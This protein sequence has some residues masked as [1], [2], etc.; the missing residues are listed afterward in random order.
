MNLKN[1]VEQKRCTRA[2]LI[3]AEKV[4]RKKIKFEGD[5]AFIGDVKKIA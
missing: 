1:V 4:S 2:I 5:V 3:G